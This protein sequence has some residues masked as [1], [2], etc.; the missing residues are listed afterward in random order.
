[1][2]FHTI[3]PNPY[4]TVTSHISVPLSLRVCHDLLPVNRLVCTIAQTVLKSESNKKERR[5]CVA[6]STISRKL[7]QSQEAREMARELERVMKDCR[8][9]CRSVDMIQIVSVIGGSVVAPIAAQERRMIGT[10]RIR[11]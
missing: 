4:S 5:T 3:E 11:A 6:I 8:S 10:I 9:H 7:A 1:M 2:G